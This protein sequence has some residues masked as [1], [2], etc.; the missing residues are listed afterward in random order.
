MKTNIHSIPSGL[1]S[2]YLGI[3]RVTFGW[4]PGDLVVVAARTSVGKSA[5][6]LTMARNMAVDHGIPVAFFSAEMTQEQLLMR[7]L[8]LESE[9]SV[10]KLRGV[11]QMTQQEMAQLNDAIGRLEQAPI[12]IA[13]AGSISVD[14]FCTKARRLVNQEHVKILIVDYLQRMSGPADARNREDE[15]S[16]ISHI[17]KDLAIEL[18]VPVIVLSQLSRKAENYDGNRRPQLSDLRDS[19]SL[20]QDADIVMLLH[21]FDYQGVENE[22]GFPGQ[23]DVIIAKNRNGAIGDVMMRFLSFEFRFVDYA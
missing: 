6:A 10:E 7:L 4:Q 20:V 23:T 17:L 2:G 19:G 5:F 13:A 1:P 15:M 18:N 21:R 22:S 8:V 9:L 12:S 14:E 3:D 16:A 11:K